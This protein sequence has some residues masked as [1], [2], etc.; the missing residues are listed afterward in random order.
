MR[1]VLLPPLLCA[2]IGWYAAMADADLAVIDAGMRYDKRRK[3]THRFT[4]AGPRGPQQITVPVSHGTPVKTWADVT[5]SDHN[6]WWK[7]AAASLAT[8][9]GGTPYFDLIFPELEALLT[10]EDTVGRPVTE[11]SLLVD[12]RIRRLTGITTPVSAALPLNLPT[13]GVV[14]D[15]RAEDFTDTAIPA[16]RQVRA[17]SLGWLPGLSILDPLFNLGGPATLQLLRNVR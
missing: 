11:Y 14:T 16:Y 17:D 3:A 10:S 7:Q 2:P 4:I 6:H 1:V 5:V 15:L 9:Y 13:D 12:A 8:A